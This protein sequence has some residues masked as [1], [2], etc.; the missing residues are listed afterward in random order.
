M[1]LTPALLPV[2]A[3]RN[4]RCEMRW[5]SRETLIRAANSWHATFDG[6]HSFDTSKEPGPEIVSNRV[7]I[8]TWNRRFVIVVPYAK[9]RIDRS[10][11]PTDGAR[12][13]LQKYDENLTGF[14]LTP[15]SFRLGGVV[16]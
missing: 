10:V 8:F 3:Q 16:F 13:L 4:T 11:L 15:P 9:K 5:S 6:R 14:G 1:E 7:D 12:P 2:V